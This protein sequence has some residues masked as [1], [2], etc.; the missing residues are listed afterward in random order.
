MVNNNV[1]KDKGIK[2]AQEIAKQAEF[3][4]RNLSGF[5]K[6][7]IPCIAALWSLFQL[8]LLRPL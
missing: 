2:K 4:S 6:Y 7:L 5:S 1:L 3:G 8:Y